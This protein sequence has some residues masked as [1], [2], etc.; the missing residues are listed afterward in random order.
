V[1]SKSGKQ[2]LQINKHAWSGSILARDIAGCTGPR[3]VDVTAVS[4]HDTERR[5]TA[6]STDDVMLQ[7]GLC[8]SSCAGLFAVNVLG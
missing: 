3:G 7:A 6:R 2:M 5:R 4:R 8:S 1:S